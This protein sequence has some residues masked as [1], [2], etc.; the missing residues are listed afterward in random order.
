MFTAAICCCRDLGP[1]QTLVRVKR[2]HAL[3]GEPEYRQTASQCGRNVGV[4]AC[5]SMQVSKPTL[6]TR[7]SSR[8]CCGTAAALNSSWKR[9]AVGTCRSFA[10]PLTSCCSPG[11][12]VLTA[13]ALTPVT[14]TGCAKVTCRV[15]S[16]SFAEQPDANCCVPQL[17]MTWVARVLV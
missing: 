17:P 5:E 1:S 9:A 4:G 13:V 2:A 6:S 15:D 7:L 11:C 8:P 10:K 16:R 12:G 3:R 14:T